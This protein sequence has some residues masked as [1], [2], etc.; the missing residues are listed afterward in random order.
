MTMTTSAADRTIERKYRA[1]ALYGALAVILVLTGCPTRQVRRALD[2]RI[3]AAFAEVAPPPETGR[4]QVGVAMMAPAVEVL[5]RAQLEAFGRA[6]LDTT[7]PIPGLESVELAL[8]W[9]RLVVELRPA[10]TLG[11]SSVFVLLAVPG[12]ISAKLGALTVQERLRVSARLPLTLEGHVGETGSLELDC[13]VADVE[14]LLVAVSLEGTPPGMDSAISAGVQAHVRDQVRE[15]P[16]DP[17]SVGQLD[18]MLEF[19]GPLPL[20]D[21]DVLAFPG[22][23]PTV[24]VGALTS[25]PVQDEPSVDP[26]TLLPGDS[27][28]AVQADDDVLAAFLARAGLSGKLGAGIVSPPDRVDLAELRVDEGGFWTLLR[29]WRIKP[30]S[31][32]VDI[33]ATGVLGWNEDRLVLELHSLERPEKG[34]ILARRLPW[35]L[36]LGPV[37][38]P[39]PIDALETVS[40]GVV[41]RGRLPEDDGP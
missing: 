8:E 3:D 11:P 30:P 1:A 37:D 21:V 16:L 27:D 10:P 24:F 14:Q 38:L 15:Q 13:Q 40:G 34:E 31:Q 29:I 5:I 2:Q 26:R 25:L 41:V 35:T 4:Y 17:L 23:K 6:T 19:G 39:W 18:A 33:R 28:W 22:G 32:V 12:A 20:A 7:S 36:E 9:E